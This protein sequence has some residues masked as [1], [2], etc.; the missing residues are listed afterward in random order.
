MDDVYIM[1][2]HFKK[3]MELEG[4][5]GAVF[6]CFNIYIKNSN[7]NNNYNDTNNKNNE[8]ERGNKVKR[9]KN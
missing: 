5:F 1:M 3:K 7:N 9:M 6:D 4:E 2:P 8:R